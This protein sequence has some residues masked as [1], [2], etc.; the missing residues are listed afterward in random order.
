[1][2]RPLD[3]YA[4]IH[5]HRLADAVRGDT[6]VCLSPGQP[7]QLGGIYSVGIHPWNTTA[8]IPLSRLR[9]LVAMARDERVVAIGECGFDALRGG[10]AECQRRVFEF[11][12]KLAERVAKPL[13][14]HAVKSDAHL[15]AAIKRIKPRQRWIIHGFRGKPQAAL[16]MLRAGFSLS[17]GLKFNP[18]VEAVIPP[19]R[20]Y[21][22]SDAS[23]DIDI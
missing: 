16:Q 10:S 1:M 7:M 13:I 21:R 5:S 8:D 15:I 6:V 3:K 18:E 14:I 22:E 9:Q 12:A 19:D 11:H 20:L 23:N 4:D 2:T 17:L